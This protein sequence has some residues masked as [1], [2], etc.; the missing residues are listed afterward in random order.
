VA[1]TMNYEITAKVCSVSGISVFDRNMKAIED[2]GSRSKGQ[3]TCVVGLSRNKF[4]MKTFPSLPLRQVKGTEYRGN[5]AV[6]GYY[7]PLTLDKR[8]NHKEYKTFE[9]SIMLSRGKEQILIGVASLKFA[10][11]VIETEVDVPIHLIGSSKAIQILTNAKTGGKKK[12]FG[13]SECKDS[14][15]Q[16]NPYTMINGVRTVSFLGGDDG[17]KYA[18]DKGSFI[19]L[20][21]RVHVFFKSRTFDIFEFCDFINSLI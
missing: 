9:V 8:L 3:V 6:W 5:N 16:S 14:F 2:S 17:R 4:G 19:R 1:D 15:F 21:V 10:S 18:L 11:A 20:K 12:M 13:K 7:N